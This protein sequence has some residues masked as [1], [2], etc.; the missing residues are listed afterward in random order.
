MRFLITGESGLFFNGEGVF[1]Q[2]N[3]EGVGFFFKNG[4]EEEV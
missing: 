2:K 1:F 3:G 4:R